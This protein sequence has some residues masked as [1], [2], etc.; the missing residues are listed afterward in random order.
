MAGRDLKAEILAIGSEL[1]MPG[2]VESNTSYLEEKLRAIGVDVAARHVLADDVELLRSAFAVSLQRADIVIA[3][4][5]L[6]PT[7]D[8]RTR[9]AAAL[10]VDRPLE[11]DAT[12]LAAIRSRFARFYR[13][14]APVN[15]RQAD[16][17]AGARLVPNENGTAPGQ[18]LDWRGRMLIL[19]PGPP[20]EMREMFE[21]RILP[22]IRDLAGGSVLVT[23]VLRVAGMG[24]SDVDQLVASIYARFDNPRTTI[25]GGPAQVELRLTGSGATVMEAEERI[26]RLAALLRSRLGDRLFTEDGRELHE[27]VAELLSQRGLTLAVAESCTGGLLSALLTSVPGSSVFF[28]R[29]YVTYSNEAKVELLGVGHGRVDEFGAVSAEVAAS[30]AEGARKAA[31]TAIGLAI[32]GIAGPDGGS[33]EKPVGL[34]FTALSGAA[35]AGVRR[36]LFPGNRA[37]VRAAAAQTALEMLRRGLLDL[38]AT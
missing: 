6:G 9:E 32:T 12:A 30:M 23:K 2:N 19:L 36:S 1:L 37:R 29:A 11:R 4:G 25:L 38:S 16:L 27:I 8:D 31:R 24:E 15:E 14:M 3:T 34:V 13:E 21:S 5:G 28:E 18:L 10:A 22:M 20:F 7:D 17:I 33:K 35:G 26:E